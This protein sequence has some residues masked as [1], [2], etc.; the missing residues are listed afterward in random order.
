MELK[1]HL[2]AGDS[3]IEVLKEVLIKNLPAEI[4]SGMGKT[5]SNVN[6]FKTA[7]SLTHHLFINYN[8]REKISILAFDLDYIKGKKAKEC[9]SNIF[10][11]NN[12]LVA[13][14][15]EDLTPTF[16]IETTKGYQFFYQLQYPIFTKNKKALKYLLDIKKGITQHLELD[17]IASNRLHGVYRNP[18][19]HNF[20]FSYYI[21]FNL[22]DFSKFALNYKTKQSYNFKNFENLNLNLKN[23]VE[24]NRNHF[25]FLEG[26]K[27]AKNKKKL[28]EQF[29]IE[30][31]ENINS[32]I[33]NRLDAKEILKISKN[34]YKY[35][36]ENKIYF[37]LDIDI[38]IGV[39]GFEKMKNLTREEY[40]EETKKRQKEASKRTLEIRNK[41][42]NLNS[43]E[44]ARQIK[45]EKNLNETIKK[46]KEAKEILE[47]EN[48]KITKVALANLTN[49]SRKTIIKYF[50]EI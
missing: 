34:V 14:L 33:E 30:Y 32:K 16:V 46:I 12:Y 3:E 5:T 6:T 21:N 44:K 28:E 26:L 36:L 4:K 40:L 7:Y 31:L 24:G 15:G 8:T 17:A 18:L 47:K 43:L 42:K 35:Y 39:M 41:E 1:K 49:L 9:F 38:D 48:K 45:I 11:F 27:F 2:L 50:K 25:L 19:L 23:L 10:Q 13:K 37:N 29:L 22:K 20:Y